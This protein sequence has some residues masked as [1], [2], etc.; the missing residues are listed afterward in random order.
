GVVPLTCTESC[1]RGRCIPH[2]SDGAD[3]DLLSLPVGGHGTGGVSLR[4]RPRP[5]QTD[6]RARRGARQPLDRRGTHPAPGGSRNGVPA[7]PPLVDRAGAVPGG[8]LL[9]AWRVPAVRARL[10]ATVP[11][12]RRE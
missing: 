9:R 10:W 5:G 7:Q 11:V 2:G 8:V 3:H 12:K 6:D 4:V 1:T